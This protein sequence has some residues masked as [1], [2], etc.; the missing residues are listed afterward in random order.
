MAKFNFIFAPPPC[1]ECLYL[2]HGKSLRHCP[3]PSP[4]TLSTIKNLYIN[5]FELSPAL[6][7][8]PSF[9]IYVQDKITLQW[10]QLK[11]IR[12][13]R[14]CVCMCTFVCAYERVRL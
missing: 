2:R 4:V 14:V 12:F 10:N 6:I 7:S 9:Q 8:S 13:V 5:M 11:D 3:M 1:S